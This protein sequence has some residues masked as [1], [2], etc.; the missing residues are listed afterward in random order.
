[1]TIQYLSVYMTVPVDCFW[2][3]KVLVTASQ[4]LGIVKA[5][6]ALLLLCQFDFASHETVKRVER[7][8][9]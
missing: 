1:M 2:R 8:S 7:M 3:K 6:I 5:Q 9:T 4:L